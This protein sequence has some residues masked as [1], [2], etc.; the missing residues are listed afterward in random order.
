MT[1]KAGVTNFQASNGWLIN[2]Q[3]R[4]GIKSRK[5]VGESGLVDISKIT[6]FKYVFKQKISEYEDKNIFNCDESGLFFRC[7][8]PRTL[9][10]THEDI[11]SGKFSK[12]RETIHFCCSLVGEKHDPLI[13]GKAKNPKAIKNIDL[14]KLKISYAGNKKAWM[15]L[16][17]F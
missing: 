15:T 9:A 6:D 13:I 3:K 7:S 14:K 12:E 17:I 11:I 2:F 8:N 10:F 1:E 5:I 16:E 4:H